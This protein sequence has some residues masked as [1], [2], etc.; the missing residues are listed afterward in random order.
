VETPKKE[1]QKDYEPMKVAEVGHVG[2]VLEGGGGKLSV[3]AAD[4]GDTRKP[5]GQG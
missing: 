3:V 2:E 1:T 5:K 4:S